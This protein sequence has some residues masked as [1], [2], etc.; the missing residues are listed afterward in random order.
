MDQNAKTIWFNKSV[1]IVNTT[2]QH[3]DIIYVYVCFCSNYNT[4]FLF[5]VIVLPTIR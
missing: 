4:Y 1:A 3:L 2:L 5:E